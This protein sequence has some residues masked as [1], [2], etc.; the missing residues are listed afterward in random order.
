MRPALRVEP[1]TPARW[2]DVEQLF[3]PRGACA[4]CWCM[5]PRIPRKPW[6]AQKGDGNK[7]AFRTLVAGGA[8]PGVLGYLGAEPVAWCAIAPRDD[9][10]LLSRSRI[11][12]PVDAQP[13]WSIVCLF[14]S[15]KHRRHGLSVRMIDGAVAWAKR[16]G[17]R[18]VEG[19]PVEPRSPS[20]PAA[21]AWW[22]T[23]SAFAR[24]GFREIAR[25]S[26]SRP[27]MRRVLTRS[28][29]SGAPSRAR[30]HRR[31]GRPPRS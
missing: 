15:S 18:I 9:T 19:Y 11:L 13:G 4:G 20:M 23:A 17:A 10:P 5:F 24:A 29:G 26:A 27:I 7:R 6:D 8:V 1:L 25:R 30:T 2:D 31:P 3:G 12:K 16:Q 22:G 21:F 14:V 28:A